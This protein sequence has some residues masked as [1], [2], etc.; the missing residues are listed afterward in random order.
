MTDLA[1][2]TRYLVR[3]GSVAGTWMIWD[4]TRRGP[5]RLEHGWATELS[6]E[7]ARQ[8]LEELTPT[9]GDR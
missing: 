3:K 1:S 8:L 5:A 7:R 6:E 4:R 9:N 2:I